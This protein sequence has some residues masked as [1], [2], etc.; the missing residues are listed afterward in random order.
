[1]KEISTEELKKLLNENKHAVLIDCRANE[2]YI[3]EHIPGAVNLPLHLV[4]EKHE[5]VFP[6]R[7]VL[8]ITSCESFMCS[9]SINCYKKLK[10]LSYK[11]LLE[12]S[13]GITDWKANGFETIKENS[14]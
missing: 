13:G 7:N 1:M 5:D 14:L 12:F 11:N 8:I 6:D 3:K 2:K 9:T 10:A 4:E